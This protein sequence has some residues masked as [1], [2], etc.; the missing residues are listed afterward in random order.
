MSTGRES[1]MM[2]FN[3]RESGMMSHNGR[4]SEIISHGR[5]SVD[6]GYVSGFSS[7]A[8]TPHSPHKNIGKS[9]DRYTLYIVKKYKVCERY[10]V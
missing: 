5:D 6:Y 7:A 1:G 10:I 3:G 8:Q 9:S 2:S 4:E